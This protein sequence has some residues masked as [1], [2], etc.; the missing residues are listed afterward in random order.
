MAGLRALEDLN[1][2]ACVSIK[3]LDA[4][5]NNRSLQ[6]L[7]LPACGALRDFAFLKELRALKSLKIGYTGANLKDLKLVF[8]LTGLESLDV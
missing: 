5:G 7:N 4:L 3:D 6:R 8:A 2:S 1:L